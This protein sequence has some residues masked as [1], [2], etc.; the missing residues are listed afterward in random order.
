[1]GHPLQRRLRQKYNAN[2]KIVKDSN[3]PNISNAHDAAVF[4][5]S[6]KIWGSGKKEP[7]FTENKIKTDKLKENIKEK[8]GKANHLAVE[9]PFLHWHA[10]NDNVINP[11]VVQSH[12]PTREAVKLEGSCK[13]LEITE[14]QLHM[15]KMELLSSSLKLI[16]DALAKL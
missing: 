16:E 6:R 5:L 9:Y 4:D 8:K 10:K 11:L 13:K 15:K 2:A 1:M 3:H 12:I 14:I 7:V